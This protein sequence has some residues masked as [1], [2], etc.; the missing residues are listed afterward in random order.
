MTAFF[1]Y[2]GGDDKGRVWNTKYLPYDES[3][4]KEFYKHV[5][6]KTRQRYRLD[7]LTAA[8]PGA[9][10]SYEFHG[11]R[12]S[13]DVIGLIRS[14]IWRSSLLKAVFIFQRGCD[15]KLKGRSVHLQC[16]EIHE[17]SLSVQIQDLPGPCE[18]N[19]SGLVL[20]VE[21]KPAIA[22]TPS[23]A[24]V[25]TP[26]PAPM[27]PIHLFAPNLPAA[28]PANSR[29]FL[30][31]LAW[32]LGR[33]LMLILIGFVMGLGV[34]RWQHRKN[35]GEAM[36]ADTIDNHFERPHLLLNNVTLPT[37]DGTTQIDHVLV[38]DTGIFV[39]ETKHYSGWIFGN[40]S[41]S[42]W[43][44][45]IFRH[46]TPF[47]NPLRQ[48]HGHVKTLQALFELPEE[49]F[50]SLVVFTG[51]AEFKSDLGSNVLRLAG[52]ISFLAAERPVVFDERKMTYIVGRIEM[53]RERRSL[54]TDEY[55]INHVR[56]RIAG[57]I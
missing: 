20:P 46:K 5:D 29:P 54:E 21:D 19:F 17:Q 18:L 8:K 7:N 10:V 47:Q 26:A 42:Q 52:L 11:T 50:H 24:P 2:A 12:P 56:D 43:T 33:L 28:S 13:K 1:Y 48:N 14:E 34:T 35:L 44:Q 31:S 32:G 37:A 23:P 36:V 25:A 6:E 4:V 38:A 53:K 3:Y 22:P 15:L 40:P 41:D 16:L 55:H 51:D 9:S 39:I 57:K 27:M 30:P 45:T 49:N